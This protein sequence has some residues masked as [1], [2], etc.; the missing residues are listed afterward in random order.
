MHMNRIPVVVAIAA[1]AL[2]SAAGAQA[3]TWNIDPNHTASQF[4]VKHLLVSTVRGQFDRTTGTITWDGKD[5]KSIQVQVEI[6]AASVNTRV[7]MRDNDL[8]STNFFDV[9]QF[10]KITFTSKQVDVVDASHFKLTGAL[11]MHGV[12]KDVVLDVEGPSTPIPQGPNLR[13]G[14]TASVKINRHDF[15]L[16]YSRAVEAAPVVGDEIT[17][18]IDIEAVRRAS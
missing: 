7:A 13:T 9:A 10:P 17:I 15:G 4:A 16:N 2:S 8:R 18:T 5:P 3:Q 11:T 1:A 12:T 14:A 6:D